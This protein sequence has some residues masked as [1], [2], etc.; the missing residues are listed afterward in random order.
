MANKNKNLWVKIV[1]NDLFGARGN[2]IPN[3]ERKEL[4][5]KLEKGSERIL[6]KAKEIDFVP[7]FFDFKT[8]CNSS[9]GLKAYRNMLDIENEIHMGWEECKTKMQGILLEAKVKTE[10]MLN[11]L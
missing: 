5:E 4:K 11:N 7:I 3:E 10:Q 9:Q 1:S 8:E 2:N 6:R